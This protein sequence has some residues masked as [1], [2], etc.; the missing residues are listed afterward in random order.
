MPRVR[1]RGRPAFSIITILTL[2]LGI[3]AN[4]AIFSVVSAV[5][6]KPLPYS[7]P[8][9]L[10]YVS[11]QF[12]RLGFDQFWV[13]PP[14]F[15][16]LQERAQSFASIGAFSSAQINLTAPDR[17]R[18]VNFVRVSDGLLQT[19]GTRAEFGRWFE[20]AETRPNGPDVVILT[21]ELWRSAF[22]ANANTLGQVIEVG[23]VRRT[24]VG[25]MP[26]GFDVADL[27]VELLL[28]LVGDPANRQNRG[29]HF[30]YL[31]A[32]LKDGAT[33]ATARA[34]LETL[35]AAWPTTIARPANA[36]NGPHTPDPQGHRL[37]Y[38][39]L[40]EQIVG[41]ARTAVV[42]LQGAVVLILLIACANIAN[43]LL[44]RAE[45]RH[46]E[47]AVRA[48]LGAGARQ[49]LTP[50][51]TEAML[52]S[53][54]GGALGLAVGT[55]GLRLAIAS[56]PEA[57]PRTAAVTLDAR[58]MTFA[59]LVGIACAVVF[60]LTPLWH[61]RIGAGADALKEGGQR[62]TAGVGRNR[63]RRAL[64]AGEVALALA[65]V[66]GAGLLLRTVFNLSRVD[67]GFSRDQLVTFGFSLPATRYAQPTDMLTFQHRLLDALRAVPGVKDAAEMSG[68]P[69]SRP[70]NANDTDIDGY[71]PT[72]GGP[73]ENVDYYQTISPGYIQTL[74]IP[75]VEGRAFLPTDAGDT[76]VLINQ[77]M[78]R[79]FFPDQSAAG[80]SPALLRPLH[81][82]AVVHDHRRRQGRQA[83]RRRERHRH[84]AVFQRRAV[85]EVAAQFHAA[86]D[87]RRH[88]H[89]V[90]A[91]GAGADRSANA[92][93]ARSRRAGDQ[94]AHDGRRV[95]GCDGTA[96]AAR[97]TCWACSRRSRCCWRRS[98]RSACCRTWSASGGARSASAWRSAPAARSCCGWCCRRACWWRARVSCSASPS[99]SAQ[100]A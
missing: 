59:L 26:P 42:V 27:H 77:T 64:V 2:A 95:R 41:S 91:G 63:V 92:G 28:P 10:V 90:D 61:M 39:P 73:L 23:G 3:G 50:F 69:P 79:R 60:S 82:G 70:L 89:V 47:L 84:R 18:R 87:E 88:A 68:L 96:A 37:R 19:L 99:R 67:S 93:G 30:L 75:V 78:A 44:A 5:L 56:F 97:A 51:M 25:I 15:F 49:L 72:P 24:V 48:A 81:G 12:K 53:L 57:L 76:T 16:E 100:A 74:G 86:T 80:P 34:E 11:T 7:K 4:T 6:L 85:A 35:L 65:L 36:T 22:G 8:E 33:I 9:Q 45:S 40:H 17:P 66:V 14:E 94:A 98:G 1:W 83:G 31:I 38:D 52:L 29:S 46:K 55:V 13:S 20:P 71:T 32:R 58:V 43:L 21:H 54:A 62:T